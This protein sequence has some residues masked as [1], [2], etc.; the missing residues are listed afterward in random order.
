[1]GAFTLI[2]LL[3][4]MAIIAIL[5]SL[6][7][8]ALNRAKSAAHGAKCTSNL[9]QLGIAN[10]LYLDDFSVYPL[11]FE[12]ETGF[13]PLRHWSDKLSSY[14]SSKWLDPLC[15]CPGVTRTNVLPRLVGSD[16]ITPVGSYDMNVVGT[17]G[18]AD[19]M[20]PGWHSASSSGP[21]LSRGRAVG[22]SEVIAPANLFLFGD[23]NLYFGIVYRFGH[24][25]YHAHVSGQY[26]QAAAKEAAERRRHSGRI[27]V[28][29]CDGHVERQKQEILYSQEPALARRWNRDNESH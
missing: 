14:T 18:P 21:L 13:V 2:E 8:P 6:L 9:R 19:P 10:A 3:V 15:R 1:M 16:W 28:V 25:N 23:A 11:F 27:N 17:P 29:L 5:A 26:P 7:L 4:V 12:H 20:G 22:A 24:F